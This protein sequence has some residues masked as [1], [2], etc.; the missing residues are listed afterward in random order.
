M[1]CITY[2]FNLLCFEAN[3]TVVLDYQTRELVFKAWP[4]RDTSR[5]TKLCQQLNGDRYRFSV[6][7]GT[8]IYALQQLLIYDVTKSIQIKVPCSEVG[9][10]GCQQAFKAKSAIFSMEYQESKQTITEVVSNLRRLDFNRSACGSES[11]LLYGRNVSLAPAYP[12][13]ISN[14]FKTVSV[15]GSCKYPL[16]SQATIDLNKQEDRTAIA[17]LFVYPNFT[18]AASTYRLTPAMFVQKS[19]PCAL[20]Q[21]AIPKPGLT[22]WCNNM[23]QT[24]SNTSYGQF[25]VTYYVPGKIPNRDGSLTRDANYT[26]IYRSNKVQ[27]IVQG[28]LDCYSGQTL[29]VF[30]EQLLLVNNLNPS[31]NFCA[32]PI[33]QFIKYDYDR[34]V[35]RITFQEHEDFTVGQVFTVDFVTQSQVLNS[36]FEWLSCDIS[37]NKSHCLSVLSQR[38][39][40][41]TFTLSAQQLFFKSS[42]QVQMFLLQ[43]ALEFSCHQ[44]SQLRLRESEIC[45]SLNACSSAEP[46]NSFFTYSIFSQSNVVFNLSA[47]AVFPN[48]QNTYCLNYPFSSEQII[49]FKTLKGMVRIDAV[50]IS[51]NEVMDETGVKSVQ[52]IHWMVVGTALVMG[53]VVGISVKKRWV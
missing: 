27:D 11:Y 16:D 32:K 30:D 17:E 48:V 49:Q 22:A 21:Y 7:T 34:M 4:R 20:I 18:L 3:N 38:S 14:L 36:S 26:S 42:T 33:K 2:S 5:E 8:Y 43:P 51:I 47:Q 23:V 13:V 9:V 41:K 40:L 10:L 44:S 39:Q 6:Q 25:S 53:L 50:F 37:T 28:Y 31:I 15:P 29:Q 45:V 24:L 35:T 12:G 19:Y 52:N 46:V 1:W